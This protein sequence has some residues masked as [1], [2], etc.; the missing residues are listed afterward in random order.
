MHSTRERKVDQSGN[1]IGSRRLQ[2]R[3]LRIL[4][5]DLFRPCRRG[6]RQEIQD[7]ALP[8]RQRVGRIHRRRLPLP[9]R[10]RQGSHA[11]FHARVCDRHV[12]RAID[13]H[14]QG[15]D[16]WVSRLDK[17][18]FYRK[19]PRNIA[20]SHN[21]HYNKSFPTKH[22]RSLSFHLPPFLRNSHYSD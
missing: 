13:H 15:R 5:E 8:E 2:I 3:R 12:Q 19:N 21:P 16:C 1:D 6:S 18:P 14:G 17:I 7:D 10:S 11:R 9:L 4:Q 20:P 22:L